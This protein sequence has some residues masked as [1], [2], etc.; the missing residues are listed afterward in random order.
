MQLRV[1]MRLKSKNNPRWTLT[2]R[3]I[4]L[5]LMCQMMRRIHVIIHPLSL[6]G[7]Q[8][9]EKVEILVDLS[10]ATRI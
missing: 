8:D 2:I 1:P 5:M 3:V 9:I 6:Y 4:R 10:L 7:V